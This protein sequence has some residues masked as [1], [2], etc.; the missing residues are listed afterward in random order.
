[1]FGLKLITVL[2]IFLSLLNL[3]FQDL[4]AKSYH[5]HVICA[6]LILHVKLI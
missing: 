2:H 4:K 5:V 3:V 1:M 6:N